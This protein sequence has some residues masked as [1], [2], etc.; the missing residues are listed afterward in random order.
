MHTRQSPHPQQPQRSCGLRWAGL[1]TGLVVAVTGGGAL[2]GASS[3]F[4]AS[5]APTHGT[6]TCAIAGDECGNAVTYANSHDGGGARVLAVE[7]DTE[8]HGGTVTHRV[9]DIR[10]QTNSGIFVEHVYRDDTAPYSD[11]I[12]WQSRAENQNPGSG[13]AGSS[14]GTSSGTSPDQGSSASSQSQDKGGS[15]DAADSPDHAGSSS[16]DAA[17]APDHPGSVDGSD[18]NRSSDSPDAPTTPYSAGVQAA[19]LNLIAHLPAAW[20]SYAYQLTGLSPTFGNPGAM[21]NTA[22]YED[23]VRAGYTNLTDHLVPSERSFAR[24]LYR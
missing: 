10:V 16:S 4:A 1:G 9:F 11:G 8:A 15:S 23:G 17:D 7:A 2:V 14:A 6:T 18:P 12:W 21:G 13:S 22:A 19:Y 24:T 5:T 3:A 20:R